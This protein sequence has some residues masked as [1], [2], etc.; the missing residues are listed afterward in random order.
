MAFDPA[1]DRKCVACERRQSG[2]GSDKK[3]DGE[4]SRQCGWGVWLLPHGA[5]RVLGDV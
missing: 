5:V 3:R 4:L 1:K 2:G